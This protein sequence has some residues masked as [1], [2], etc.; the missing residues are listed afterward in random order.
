MRALRRALAKRR[1][2]RRDDRAREVDARRCTT[3][4]AGSCL[5][6]W[7]ER[8]LVVVS[9]FATRTTTSPDPAPS[10]ERSTKFRADLLVRRLSEL[11][12]LNCPLNL[13]RSLAVIGRL[14]LV[15]A[16]QRAVRNSALWVLGVERPGRRLGRYDELDRSS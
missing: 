9:E 2:G 1:V 11:I 4:G 3:R 10:S 14:H 12:C 15:E 13:L 16:A 7:G 5:C 8:V 6:G